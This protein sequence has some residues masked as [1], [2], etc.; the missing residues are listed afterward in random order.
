MGVDI[1]DGCFDS[2]RQRLS[3]HGSDNLLSLN[4]RYYCSLASTCFGRDG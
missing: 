3:M 2:L 1:P 4:M